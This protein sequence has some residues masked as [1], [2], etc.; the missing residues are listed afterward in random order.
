MKRI[1]VLILLL[2]FLSGC[3]T[4]PP[5]AQVAATTLPVYEFTS[6]LVGEDGQDGNK[7]DKGEDG[8]SMFQSVTQDE[9]YVYFTLA[10]GTVIKIAK[11]EGVNNNQPNSEFIFTITYDANGGEGLMMP[12]TFYYGVAKKIQAN[13]FTINSNK[14]YVEWNTKPDG[15]GIAYQENQKA[16]RQG[17]YALLTIGQHEA[18]E[19]TGNLHF[20]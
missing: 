17:R 3:Q 8:D 9:N 13:A 14:I 20:R 4:P 19:N 5:A 15:T 18:D 11:G 7:G 1:A 6:A 2:L 16:G 10:D 12:D